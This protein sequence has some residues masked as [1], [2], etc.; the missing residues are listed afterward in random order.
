MNKNFFLNMQEQAEPCERTLRSLHS[1]IASQDAPKPAK[2]FMKWAP[3]TAAACVLV[4]AMMILMP[5]L[6]GSEN[7][8]GSGS[9]LSVHE[10]HNFV[11]HENTFDF[12]LNL[13]SMHGD[14]M[15]MVAGF[16][17]IP[18][19]ELAEREL[20]TRLLTN[21]ATI[22]FAADDEALNVPY[23]GRPVSYLN[24]TGTDGV[25]YFEYYLWSVYNNINGED[26]TFDISE[27]Q[28][29]NIAGNESVF[30]TFH[31]TFTANYILGETFTAS[32]AENLTVM[33]KSCFFKG[34]E[35]SEH[36]I[37]LF[38]DFYE[39]LTHDESRDLYQA[40]EARLVS[41]EVIYLSPKSSLYTPYI[42]YGF[43]DILG[44]WDDDGRPVPPYEQA[45]GAAFT[46]DFDTSQIVSVIISGQEFH[47]GR[48]IKAETDAPVSAAAEILHADS[49]SVVLA[50][51]LTLRE[52]TEDFI[53]DDVFASWVTNGFYSAG[54]DIIT[55]PYSTTYVYSI[56]SVDKEISVGDI[57]TRTHTGTHNGE[58]WEA[59]TSV[60]VSR[61]NNED[62]IITE[63]IRLNPYH[64]RF[65]TDEPDSIGDPFDTTIY[66][67]THCGSIFNTRNE[68]SNK[69]YSFKSDTW[70]LHRVEFADGFGVHDIAA[71]IL[72]GDEIALSTGYGAMR[73]TFEPRVIHMDTSLGMVALSYDPES[74]PDGEFT[75]ELATYLAESAIS[76]ITALDRDFDAAISGLFSGAN[77]SDTIEEMK[78]FLSGGLTT[79]TDIH[80]VSVGF[81]SRGNRAFEYFQVIAHVDTGGAN[82]GQITIDYVADGNRWSA[83]DIYYMESQ[84]QYDGTAFFPRLQLLEFQN[85]GYPLYLADTPQMHPAGELPE[86]DT[87]TGTFSPNVRGILCDNTYYFIR[88]DR[89]ACSTCGYIFTD[90]QNREIGLN[91]QNPPEP[92]N[93]PKHFIF[94]VDMNIASVSEWTHWDGGYLGHSGIDFSAPYG[95]EIYAA[96]GGRV[97][98][99]GWESPYGNLVI[100]EGLFDEWQGSRVYYGHCSEI[101]VEVGD[102]V[103]QGQ[104]IALVGHSGAADG[105]HL[106]LEVRNIHQHVINPRLFLPF[107]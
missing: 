84:R 44:D 106:H 1:K 37:T 82:L 22:R 72:N 18:R 48:P 74:G 10:L 93:F 62:V 91:L 57:F 101:L 53:V 55:T 2:S 75:R 31:A 66:F 40:L 56:F 96:A 47:L 49:E 42:E 51:T 105:A 33:G 36:S 60:T 90:E 21:G 81:G 17:I 27:I 15:L 103:T 88:A 46:D 32:F 12:D 71:V 59:K 3:L 29:Y 34:V 70:V 4:T 16:E 87:A 30:G 63:E 64:I 28:I 7:L 73:G 19:G 104:L 41:G 24:D 99:A 100:I 23:T 86:F 83:H 68:L 80:I 65:I 95:T 85:L 92:Y 6:T 54:E 67:K 79:V 52:P 77:Y 69:W 107:E 76:H 58:A 43:G 97:V 98:H 35:L 102:T 11:I 61:L 38:F 14:N 39:S 50:V 20:N 5:M 13:V 45:L 26:F 94:P 9:E 89:R 8:P 25:F 78:A